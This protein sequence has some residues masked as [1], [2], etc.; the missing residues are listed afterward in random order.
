MHRQLCQTHGVSEEY[1]GIKDLLVVD[2]VCFHRRGSGSRRRIAL[3][4]KQFE[5]FGS[6]SQSCAV[7]ASK[8]I[9]RSSSQATHE[10]QYHEDNQDG[11]NNTD[12]AVTET[13]TVSSEAA[14]EPADQEDDKN[15][16]QDESGGGHELSPLELG[17]ERL[18]FMTS[19]ASV[20]RPKASVQR[21]V[22]QKGNCQKEARMARNHSVQAS[23]ASLAS[24]ADMDLGL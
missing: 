9:L 19:T 5:S 22:L 20:R 14:A 11:A 21:N 18:N 1:L 13:V 6:S 10:N 12:A 7:L 17:C 15:D 2:V 23:P 16:N 8:K 3:K 24:V 4:A